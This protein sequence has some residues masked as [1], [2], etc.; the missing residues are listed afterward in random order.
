MVPRSCSKTTS[1]IT[2]LPALRARPPLRRP[3]QDCCPESRLGDRLPGPV[4]SHQRLAAGLG[5]GAQLGD[6]QL[7]GRSRPRMVGYRGRLIP[8]LTPTAAGMGSSYTSNP[9]SISRRAR[10]TPPSAS[11]STSMPLMPLTMGRPGRRPPAPRLEAP[12]VGR[13]VAEDQQVEGPLVGLQATDGLG[14]R[15]CGALGVPGRAVGGHQHAVVGPHRGGIAKLLGR[16][17]AVPGSAP[18]PRRRGAPQ[19]A[20]PPPPRTPR[21]GWWRSPGGWRPR[22]AVGGHV[23]LGPRRRHP[24]HAA[25]DPHGRPSPATLRKTFMASPISSAPGV[26]G[27]EHCAGAG[28]LHREQLVHVHHLEV[29]AGLGQLGGEV[30]HQQVLAHRRP[31]PRGGHPRHPSVGVGDPLAV[32]GQDRLI[33][34]CM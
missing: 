20:P 15:G 12:G 27:I 21:A 16:P 32:L 9:P 28:H 8:S 30:G 4:Q 23:D 11:R 5:V 34:P 19:A 1:S 18:S 22:Q 10:T 2:A 33:A 31:R 7:L 25:Q 14:E 13:L 17:R 6:L 3:R 24:L 26:V 29:G